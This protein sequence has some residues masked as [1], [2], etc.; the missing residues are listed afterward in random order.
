MAKQKRVMNANLY[1][2][3]EMCAMV[4]GGIETAVDDKYHP[5]GKRLDKPGCAV[6]GMGTWI[7]GEGHGDNVDHFLDERDE[8]NDLFADVSIGALQSDEAV[9]KI[10][11]QTNEWTIP[12]GREYIRVPFEKWAKELGVVRGSQREANDWA[13]VWED[14]SYV[15][16][17]S[18]GGRN[19]R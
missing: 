11:R 10:I 9:R 17:F 16:R 1:D 8:I 6:V 4:Y 5:N 3:L 7:A 15:P 13:V 18:R 12:A 14:A 2:S 19:G